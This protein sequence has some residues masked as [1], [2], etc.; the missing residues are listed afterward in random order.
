[1]NPSIDQG[2]QWKPAVVSDIEMAFPAHALD[3]MPPMEE[4]EAGLNALPDHGQKWRDLQRRW[5]FRGLPSTTDF[6]V[7]DGI[8][9]NQA[10]RHLR[11]IQGS[12]A[13]KHQHKEAAFAYLA[14]LWFNDVTFGDEAT[15][16]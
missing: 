3:I 9:G 2:E 5:F 8:D 6:H 1:M 13:P 15:D 11:A 14:S 12:F 4:C 7:K 10:V 16:A